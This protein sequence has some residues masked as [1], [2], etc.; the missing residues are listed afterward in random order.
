MNDIHTPSRTTFRTFGTF[1]VVLSL[2]GA[3]LAPARA[4]SVAKKV[5]SVD[6]YTKWK[7]INGAS[8]S[9]DGKWVTYVVSLTNTAPADAKP[10]LHLLRLD[11]NQDV[12]V[13]N[14]SGPAF[15]ADSKWVAYQID[16]NSGGRGGRGGRGGNGGAAPAPGATTPSAPSAPGAA[17]PGTQGG[18]GANTP[19][20][21]PRRVELRNLATGAVQAWQDIQSF[22]FSATSSQLV[23]RRR[24]PGAQGA[25]A[26]GR[27]AGGGGAPGGAPGGA[28]GGGVAS[29]GSTG[30]R[31]ADVILHD[32]ANGRD[33]LLGSVGEISFN[34]KGDLLAY[35]VDN[36]VRD[37]N[38]LFVLDLRNGRVNPLDNDA[39]S[40]SRL[41]WNDGGTG[42]AVLKGVD[43]DKMRERDNVLIVYP[44]VQ[45]ALG[46]IDAAP[47]K[48]DPVK[49]ANF[50]KGWV[51]SDRAALDWSEDNHRVFL[52]IKEQV[53]APDTSTRRR[54]ADEVADVDIWNTKD[55]RIQSQQMTR[56]EAD[57]NFTY[58]EAFDVA[59]SKFIPLADSTMR[60]IDVSQDGRWAIGRDTR[61]YISDYK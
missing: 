20:A 7:S 34:K 50:P 41:T 38:G 57:R 39:R 10:V 29:E 28:L 54:N 22:T 9:S 19:P 5:L 40:Y 25:P 11:N 44:D 31:G 13:A 4:Q 58:R 60:E 55:E 56:A 16:P 12:E 46:N 61:G 52:G 45:T 49:T 17:T 33:Q 26:G 37:G 14:A 53:P 30:A 42:L 21:P 18:R 32:L 48:L 6:D 35:T 1:A 59:S 23:L 24:A 36:T 47:A 27:G 15:S 2:A 8:V 3:A 51:V 43:V